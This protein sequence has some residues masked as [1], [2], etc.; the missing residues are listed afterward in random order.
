VTSPA[1][2]GTSGGADR[3]ISGIVLA[4]GRSTR[5]GSDKL[6][7]LVD[8]RPLLHRSLEAL[9]A[10]C[11]EV[12]IV[13]PHDRPPQAPPALAVSV[14]LTRDDTPAG[15]PMV[16]LAAGLREAAW[17]VVIVAAGDMPTPSLGVLRLLV[18]CVQ[19]GAL[20]SGLLEGDRLRP[21][22]C[23]LRRS[24]ALDVALSLGA[25]VALRE[26]LRRLDCRGIPE[27]AW[28]ALDPDGRTLRDVD[29]PADLE[30]LGRTGAA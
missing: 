20:A 10:L 9:A 23:A 16:G 21:L 8:G 28:R 27:P 13:G 24:E 25:G 4:G 26:L 12:V 2:P 29:R 7:A 15:G 6:A 1:I 19:D 11:A 30:G 14:R 3:T 5:F 22:P 17:P 18:D